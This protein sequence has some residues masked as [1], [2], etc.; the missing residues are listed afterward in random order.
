MPGYKYTVVLLKNEDS[1]YTVL[2]PA[3]AGCVTQGDTQALALA[4]AQEA[5]ECYLEALA[6]ENQ[7]FP[8][9]VQE[10]RVDLK[11]TEEAWIFKIVAEP[12]VQVG[13]T[14]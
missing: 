12:E 1:G 4:H 14:A 7:S 3:L 6:L 2:V 11:E 9:D 8:P 10:A 13:S 5:V